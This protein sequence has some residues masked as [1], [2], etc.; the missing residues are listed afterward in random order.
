MCTHDLLH[1]AVVAA[2]HMAANR[3]HHPSGC[4][5]ATK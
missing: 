2:L 4:K 5:R 1:K 3:A